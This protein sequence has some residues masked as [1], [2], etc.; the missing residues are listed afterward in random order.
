LSGT[1]FQP[2]FHSKAYLSVWLIRPPANVHHVSALEERAE[3][4]AQTL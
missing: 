3:L 4:L 2:V 1:I